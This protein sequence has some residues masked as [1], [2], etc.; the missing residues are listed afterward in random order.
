MVEFIV[1]GNPVPKARARTV[2][3][4][5]FTPQRTKDAETHVWTCFKQQVGKWYTEKPIAVYIDFVFEI[6]KTVK[7]KDGA[8]CPKYADVD[9]LMKLVLDALNK[10]AYKD[11]RQVVAGGYTKTYG[12]SGYTKVRIEELD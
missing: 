1:N 9:N 8:F 10:E 3:G 4:H 6:P 2:K 11:D 5:S 12:K 7:V